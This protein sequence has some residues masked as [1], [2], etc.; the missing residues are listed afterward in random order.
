VRS[1]DGVS[2]DHRGALLPDGKPDPEPKHLYVSFAGT[3]PAH[4]A[5][6]NTDAQ[7]V[8]AGK[9]TATQAEQALKYAKQVRAKYPLLRHVSQAEP[10]RS[11]GVMDCAVVRL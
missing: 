8:I 11:S 1:G 5:D 4:H 7:T 6:I 9:L 3:N 2:G 10:E